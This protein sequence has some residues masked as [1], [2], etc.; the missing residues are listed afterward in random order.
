MSNDLPGISVLATCGACKKARVDAN[1][2]ESRAFVKKHS[3]HGSLELVPEMIFR[4]DYLDR[5]FVDVQ[6]P[7]LTAIRLGTGTLPPMLTHKAPVFGMPDP[8]AAISISRHH[9]QPMRAAMPLVHETPYELPSEQPPT[10]SVEPLPVLRPKILRFASLDDYERAVAILA[11]A[12]VAFE[13]A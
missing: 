11:L 3:R 1:D 13:T 5:G 9:R 10:A 2:A 7:G 6:R 8:T 12:R 4:S